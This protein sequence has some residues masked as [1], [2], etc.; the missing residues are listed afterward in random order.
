MAEE[1]S[2]VM[3]C[4]EC[5]V[6]DPQCDWAPVDRGCPPV[7]AVVRLVDKPAVSERCVGELQHSSTLNPLRRKPSQVE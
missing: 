1:L 7:V 4:P 6:I 3:L 5:T 2:A